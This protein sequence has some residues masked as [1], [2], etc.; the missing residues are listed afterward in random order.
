MDIDHKI[1]ILFDVPIHEEYGLLS[2][3]HLHDYGQ[4][5]LKNKPK[6]LLIPLKETSHGCLNHQKFSSELSV[7]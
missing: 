5:C 4:S 2:M 7:W 3:L 6:W 1:V